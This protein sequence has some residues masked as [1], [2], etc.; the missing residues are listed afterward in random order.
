MRMF[1]VRSKVHGHLTF[2]NIG[3][4][5]GTYGQTGEM[6]ERDLEDPE[7]KKAQQDGRLEIVAERAPRGPVEEA[8]DTVQFSK[9]D[10]GAFRQIML[11]CADRVTRGLTEA[12][13]DEGERIRKELAASPRRP[14]RQR[15]GY[16]DPPPR[17]RV[18]S[19][20]K[21]YV[22]T[23]SL[24]CDSGQVDVQETSEDGKDM[25]ESLAALRSLREGESNGG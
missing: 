13:R 6:S 20:E 3:K 24:S 17:R 4:A 9:K 14:A 18:P 19:E 22:F 8:A 1:E 7:V 16:W 11:E 23:P 2:S 21:D 10:W 15:D 5:F 12:I 25:M